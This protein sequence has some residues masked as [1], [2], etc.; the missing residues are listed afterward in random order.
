MSTNTIACDAA[1]LGS[2]FAGLMCARKLARLGYRVVVIEPSNKVLAGASGRNEGWLHAGTYHALSI[3]EMSQAATV[4]RRCRYGWAQIQQDFPECLEVDEYP[5]IAIAARQ[6]IDDVKERWSAAGVGY[7]PPPQILLDSLTDWVTVADDEQAFL[8]DDRGIDVR[9]LAARLLHDFRFAGGELLVSSHPRA[10]NEESIE[11]TG[12]SVARVG[13]RVL[14]LATGYATTTVCAEL[15]L[16]APSIRLWRSHLVSLPRLAPASVFS[17]T[18]GEAAMINH[19]SWSIAGL[20]EDAALIPFPTY[21]PDPVVSHRLLAA[22]AERFPRAP[23]REAEITACVK[24][25]VE[26]EPNATRSLNVRVSE[27]NHNALSVLPGKM[28]EA[29]F[30]ADY[31]ARLVFDKISPSDVTPRRIDLRGR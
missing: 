10:L 1:I 22:V 11:L 16:E 4:A 28:T 12:G 30:T 23:M 15:G 13:F 26:I 6:R 14:I 25:D 31:A 2:G 17:I 9:I 5:A 29:P 19:G 20:N 27:L 21:E 7:R 3:V 24:V 18:P 8:V